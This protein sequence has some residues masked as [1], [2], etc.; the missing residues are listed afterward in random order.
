MPPAPGSPMIARHFGSGMTMQSADI[1]FVTVTC[2]AFF[3]FAVTLAGVSI[4]ERRWAKTNGK[5]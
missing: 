4:V 2:I 3:L 5:Y 1:F